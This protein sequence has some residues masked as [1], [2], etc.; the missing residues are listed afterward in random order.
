MLSNCVRNTFVRDYKFS[1]LLFFFLLCANITFTYKKFDDTSLG[2]TFTMRTTNH[3]WRRVL[4]D[5]LFHR[6]IRYLYRPTVSTGLSE[7]KQSS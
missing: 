5:K 1:R 4:K 7:N 3:P 2:N 6:F